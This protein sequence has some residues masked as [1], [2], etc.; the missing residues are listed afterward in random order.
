[1][2]A[3][4][5]RARTGRDGRWKRPRLADLLPRSLL[6]RV[7]QRNP[8]RWAVYVSRVPRSEAEI[9]PGLGPVVEQGDRLQWHS[10]WGSRP[11]PPGTL[12][13]PCH[14][15]VPPAPDCRG[16]LLLPG[17]VPLVWGPTFRS[18]LVAIAGHLRPGEVLLRA[19]SDRGPDAVWPSRGHLGAGAGALEVAS[20]GRGGWLRLR[21][22]GED[23]PGEDIYPRL[24]ASWPRVQAICE[25]H[26][27]ER[28]L[29]QAARGLEILAA[30][31][32]AGLLDLAPGARLLDVGGGAGFFSLA[33]ACRGAEV[34]N[35][36]IHEPS[37]RGALPELAR[38][39]GV[40]DRVGARLGPM[41]GLEADGPG[42]DRI[43]FFGSLLLVPRDEAGRVLATALRLLAPGGRVLVHE[44]TC[45]SGDGGAVA[46]RPFRPRELLDLVRRAGAGRVEVFDHYGRRSR[47][48]DLGESGTALLSIRPAT[49]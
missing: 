3:E 27:I 2:L 29:A 45:G 43:C 24:L 44:L 35:R 37:V 32:R 30:A 9:L 11:T 17:S 33:M 34:L 15:L 14:Y 13:D 38:E 39:L 10:P 46:Y 47:S 1:M 7:R 28:W 48:G 18:F 4:W 22:V 31:E 12:D 26:G 36:D 23:G 42:W 5:R 19:G 21:L 41:Q 20:I 40:G 49:G 25:A 6:R 16:A 8:Q